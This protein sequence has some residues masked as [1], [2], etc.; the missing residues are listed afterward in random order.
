MAAPPV[1]PLTVVCGAFG[2]LGRA[3]VTELTASG[4]QVVAVGRPGGSGG[5]DSVPELTADLADEASVSELFAEVDL[6]GELE[7]LVNVA[8]SF[9]AGRITDEPSSVYRSMLQSNLDVVWWSCRAAAAR[10]SRRGGGAVVNVSSRAAVRDGAGA[11]AYAVAKAGVV[12]LTEVL[13]ADLASHR[14]RVNAVLPGVI[15]TPSNR[16]WMGTAGTDLA[17]PPLAIAKV[18]A[19]L[20]SEDSWPVSGAAVPVYGWS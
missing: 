16:R 6:L 13:A 17:V 19:F 15:D 2:A 4:R 20:L 5:F 18:I 8:G 14:V 12:R 7:A 9:G 1:S 3:V 10:L 11:A